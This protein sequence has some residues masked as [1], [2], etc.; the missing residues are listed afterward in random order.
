MK[1]KVASNIYKFSN[2]LPKLTTEFE[3]MWSVL[4]LT[5]LTFLNKVIHVPIF[6]IH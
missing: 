2:Y 6:I 5:Y 4:G 1:N 3:S